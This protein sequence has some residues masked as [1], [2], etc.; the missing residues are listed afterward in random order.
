MSFR[1][2]G[3]RSVNSRLKLAFNGEEEAMFTVIIHGLNSLS[4]EECSINRGNFDSLIY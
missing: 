4:K 1:A 2:G 3:T